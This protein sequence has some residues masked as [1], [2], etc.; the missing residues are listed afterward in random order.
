MVLL[1]TLL[2]TCLLLALASRGKK[3]TTSKKI[4]KEKQAD[5]LITVILPIINQNK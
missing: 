4:D 5:E 1:I 3:Y 2:V